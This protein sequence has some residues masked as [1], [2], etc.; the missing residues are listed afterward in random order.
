MP[1]AA[2]PETLW[3]SQTK[4][5]FQGAELLGLLAY[6]EPDKLDQ[7]AKA[8][9]RCG[10]WANPP[11]EQWLLTAAGGAMPLD[12]RQAER[13]AK[14]LEERLRRRL[15]AGKVAL[16]A[17]H[18][19]AT[20]EPFAYLQGRKWTLDAALRQQGELDAWVAVTNLHKRVWVSSTPVL[21][22]ATAWTQES[23]LVQKSTGELPSLFR[24]ITDAAFRTRVVSQSVQLEAQLAGCGELRIDARDLIKLR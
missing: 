23:L 7:R 9:F 10:Y 11:E 17:L 2:E 13:G 21:H 22:L 19:A 3:L 6:P 4:P 8:A 1:L 14:R 16:Q 24:L 5:E 18:I 20:G 12:R 15:L